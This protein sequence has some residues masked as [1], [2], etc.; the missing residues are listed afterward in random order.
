M[1]VER[2]M[3]LPVCCLA[4][5]H[6]QAELA[7]SDEKKFLVQCSYFEV[8]NEFLYD[9]LDPKRKSGKGAAGHGLDIKAR[10]LGCFGWCRA[11]SQLHDVGFLLFGLNRRT[12]FG[13]YM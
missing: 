11:S 5:I 7:A 3:G 2:T 10:G 1:P 12:R 9:L 13:G 4:M 8:Y 6:T